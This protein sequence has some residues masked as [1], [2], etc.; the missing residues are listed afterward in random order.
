MGPGRGFLQNYELLA[1]GSHKKETTFDWLE[2]TDASV[3]FDRKGFITLSTW[4][5]TLRKGHSVWTI[6]SVKGNGGDAQLVQLQA[7]CIAKRVPVSQV[8]NPHSRIIS[9]RPSSIG[10]VFRNSSTVSSDGLPP[11]TPPASGETRQEGFSS[12]APLSQEEKIFEEETMSRAIA[13]S[14]ASAQLD[15]INGINVSSQERFQASTS[16]SSPLS[17]LR[18][19][20]NVSTPEASVVMS[21]RRDYPETAS[22]LSAGTETVG[23]RVDMGRS[24]P[25]GLRAT[26]DEMDDEVQL[27]LAISESLELARCA[28]IPTDSQN[29]HFTEVKKSQ[30]L[31]ENLSSSG[32]LYQS[33]KTDGKPTSI[34]PKKEAEEESEKNMECTICCT[35]PVNAACVPCGHMMSCDV[36]LEQVKRLGKSCP[37]CRKPINKVLKVYGL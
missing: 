27:A 10:E 4:V 16:T 35:N 17:S 36:C 22:V 24:P 15:G 7:L 9:N 21:Q 6:Q 8:A 37:V 25:I 13:E 31:I 3:S 32:F 20:P 26:E 1:L 2:L 34:Q 12:G 5:L 33:T 11:G 30:S 18:N 23:R 29:C 19:G 14:I 28:G